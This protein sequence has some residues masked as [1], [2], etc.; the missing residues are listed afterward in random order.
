MK[1]QYIDTSSF[2]HVKTLRSPEGI[3]FDLFEASEVWD[4]LT[5]R[6]TFKWK[7]LQLHLI[8]NLIISNVLSNIK[9]NSLIWSLAEI[10]RT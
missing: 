3:V 4:Q 8:F 10:F 7:I 2:L 6:S 5:L 1:T 9:L